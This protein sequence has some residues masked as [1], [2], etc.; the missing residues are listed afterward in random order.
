CI[1]NPPYMGAKVLKQEHSVDYVNRVR[2][3]FPDVP[4]N[5][6]YCVYWFRKAHELMKPGARAGLVGTNTIRQNYSRIGGLDYIVE[7]DGHIFEAVSSM[8]WSGEA[9]VS[10]SIACWSKGQPPYKPFRL[11]V[12]NG[13][14]VLELPLI[15]SALSPNIDVHNAHNLSI[16][17]MP[18][19]VYQG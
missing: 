12:D 11:W 13:E 3:T 10:I 2:D 1:G 9:A 5:A 14:R 19:R 7:N 6:D 17:T 4:G 16:N 8:P 15:S 18:K